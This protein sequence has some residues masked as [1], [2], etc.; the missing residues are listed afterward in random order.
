MLR[1]LAAACYSRAPGKECGAAEKLAAD[2]AAKVAAESGITVLS[3][4]TCQGVFAD[5]WL[6]VTQ[7][8]RLFKLR[9]SSVVAA[10]GAY[11]QPAV[12]RNND[13]PGI[14]LGT[15]AQRLMRLWAVKPGNRAVV[16]AANADAYGVALDLLDAGVAVEAIADLGRPREEDERVA[17]V[18]ARGVQHPAGD[19]NRRGDRGR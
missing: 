11:E 15:A 3:E 4:A 7:G 1:A 14:M 8:K 6:S 19:R 12:F 18:R 10:T 9:A 13:L 17:A 2:L 16:L 5:K